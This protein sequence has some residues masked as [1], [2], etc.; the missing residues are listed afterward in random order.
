MKGTV[1]SVEFK[2]HIDTVEG[3]DECLLTIDFD[4]VYAYYPQAELMKFLNK[5]VSYAA[6]VDMVNGKSAL[7]LCE[8]NDVGHVYTV[9]STENVK[10]YVEDNERPFCNFNLRELKQGEYYPGSV[11]FL[12]DVEEGSSSPVI[13]WFDL[14]CLDR[15]SHVFKLRIF[16]QSVSEGGIDN[17]EN[18][19]KAIGSYIKFDMRLTPYGY[20][21]KEVEILP[22]EGG[23]VSPEVALA[24]KVLEGVL[25][26]DPELKAYVETKRLLDVLYDKMDG[27]P[28]YNLVRMAQEIYFINALENVSKDVDTKA[29][30]RAVFCSRVYL[31]ANN[32]KWSK[33][34]LNMNNIVRAPAMSKDRELL[35]ILDVLADEP[36]TPTKIAYIKVRQMV[37]LVIK[38]KRGESYE[39]DFIASCASV[40]SQF[41]GML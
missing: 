19:V 27:E 10:L 31:T 12:S 22:Y 21:T 38:I 35:L 15:E 39:E 28:G 40:V 41:G 13:H 9:E 5:E 16:A 33:P 29:M 1:K 3:I 11:A 34:V 36:P 30:K 14:M 32:T 6:R 37:E 17:K 7:V 24:R 4:E 18:F 26:K 2:R 20:Q 8:I 25:E 23:K